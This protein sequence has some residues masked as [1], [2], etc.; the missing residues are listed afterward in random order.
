M[1][2]G[3]RELT[4]D[5]KNVEII[6][7]RGLGLFMLCHNSLS[8]VGGQLRVVTES[9]DLQHLFRIMKLDQHI[10]VTNQL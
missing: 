6:D 10:T 2:G 1:D 5:L 8:Q 3:C 4:I 7:S 9:E